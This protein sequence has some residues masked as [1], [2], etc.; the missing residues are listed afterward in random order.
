MADPS[1]SDGNA[2]PSSNSAGIRG[3]LIPGGSAS[4]GIQGT[5]LPGADGGHTQQ[6]APANN[7]TPPSPAELDIAADRLE[8]VA[9]LLRRARQPVAPHNGIV[10]LLPLN[11]VD[12]IMF[13]RE[14]PD[15]VGNDLKTLRDTTRLIAP[16]LTLVTG[17]ENDAGF[18]ELVRR[19]GVDKSK[20]A[21]FGKGFKVWNAPS[22]D[23][24]DSL[25]S[26]ACGAFEDW[27]Y[28]LF[29]DAGGLHKPG[30]GK[31]YAMLCNIR[32]RLLVRMRNIL[33]NAYGAEQCA[34]SLF[35]GCYFASTGASADRQAFVEG[36]FKRIS[37]LENELT[38][39]AEARN[40]D[41][42]FKSLSQAAMLLNGLMLIGLVGLVLYG[43][44][45]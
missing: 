31:L 8:Y 34:D 30:N 20:G 38:W 5:I 42:R 28:S 6:E 2:P 18:T 41:N 7:A 10:T 23:N 14:I 40:E 43:F 12:N 32:S 3:T 29:H 19:V 36:V 22:A 25:S 37:E 16:V 9:L 15:A 24:L 21:R 13:A 45:G 26:Q 27:V 35:A 17:M 1:G 33:V 44:L 11:V 39:T 4:A